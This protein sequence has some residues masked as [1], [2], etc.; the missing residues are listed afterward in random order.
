M[1]MYRCT[2]NQPYGKGT[3]GLTDKKA[4]QGHYIE[5]NS[6][7]EALEKMEKLFPDD[8]QGF[9]VDVWND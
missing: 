3:P 1:T 4:R 7:K 6:E 5:A 2:R 9:T 8:T